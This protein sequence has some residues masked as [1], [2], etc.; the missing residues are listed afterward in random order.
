MALSKFIYFL[1]V[2]Q[3]YDTH[4][5]KLKNHRQIIC[6]MQCGSRFLQH[7]EDDNW[8]VIETFLISFSII[9]KE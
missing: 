4:Y 3:I 2:Q 1:K 8:K 6:T 5:D 7:N 9:T